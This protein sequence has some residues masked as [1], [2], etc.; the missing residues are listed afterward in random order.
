VFTIYKVYLKNDFFKCD[1][2]TAYKI[3]SVYLK[4]MYFCTEHAYTKIDISVPKWTVPIFCM[5]R[6]W[7]Y[8]YWHSMYRN[9]M[10][11]KTCTKSICTEIV[12]YQK[13]PI[14]PISVLTGPD[15]E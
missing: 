1:T 15:V 10:Y 5:Y 4:T 6:K 12:L 2:R 3:V 11:R 8:R 9:W 14:P 7:L 13:R